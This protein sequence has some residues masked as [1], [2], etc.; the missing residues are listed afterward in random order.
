[1]KLRQ[2]HICKDENNSR[3]SITACLPLRFYLHAAKDLACYDAA[4]SDGIQEVLEHRK[5]LQVLTPKSHL[6]VYIISN[7][8]KEQTQCVSN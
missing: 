5:Y 2:I 6:L 1:M 8:I 3:H 4:S 7:K